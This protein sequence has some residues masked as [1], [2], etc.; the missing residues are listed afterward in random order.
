M[1]TTPLD[2]EF[3]E[4]F[5]R[6]LYENPE[7]RDAAAAVLRS[8]D[9]Q[10]VRD[11]PDIRRRIDV[12]VRLVWGKHDP[13]FPV[14]TAESMARTFPDARLCVIDRA[15]LFCHEERPAEVARALLPTLTGTR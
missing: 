13:F 9:M 3:D 4:F 10:L 8:F 2:G 7:R 15:A 14:P 12:P 6:P 11:L 5:L 1:D